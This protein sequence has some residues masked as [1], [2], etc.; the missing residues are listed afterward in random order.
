MTRI[1]VGEMGRA[2]MFMGGPAGL[3]GSVRTTNSAD[4]DDLPAGPSAIIRIV[5]LVAGLRSSIRVA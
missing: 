3:W 4:G 1:S 5:Y 2:A